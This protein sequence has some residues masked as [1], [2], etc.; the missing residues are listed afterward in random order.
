[1][2]GIAQTPIESIIPRGRLERTELPESVRTSLPERTLDAIGFY[3]R[4]LSDLE[5]NVDTDP[6]SLMVVIPAH[7]E[8]T[9][10]QSTL[11]ALVMNLPSNIKTEIVVA[12]DGCTDETLE[13]I[14]EF[15]NNHSIQNNTITIDENVSEIVNNTPNELEPHNTTITIIDK[16]SNTGKVDTLLRVEEVLKY[17]E[18]APARIL[19]LDADTRIEKGTIE[20]LMQSMTDNPRLAAV[21]GRINFI[22]KSGKKIGTFADTINGVHGI[23]ELGGDWIPGA[24]GLWDIHAFIAGYETMSVKFP[25]NIIEDATMGLLT[26]AIRLRTKVLTDLSFKT[27]APESAENSKEQMERWL[28]GVAQLEDI[29]GPLLKDF[30][31]EAPLHKIVLH[32]IKGMFENASTRDA[33]LE[34]AS[35]LPYIRDYLRAKREG[36]KTI[37]ATKTAPN[38][39][40]SWH[41]KRG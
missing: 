3:N 34:V 39:R 10:I 15:A 11:E 22:S 18:K 28:T 1:M 4:R 29:F 36:R 17:K 23:T 25:E 27:L 12:L 5:A 7:N 2:S 32:Q 8:E 21:T 20:K 35:K 40:Y 41:P 14:K 6:E 13:K 38:G 31:L 30:G 9:E 33:V 24:L 16:K 26:K 37:A 19:S